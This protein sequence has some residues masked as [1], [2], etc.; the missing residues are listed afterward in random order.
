MEE[1]KEYLAGLYL[2]YRDEVHKTRYTCSMVK[3]RDIYIVEYIKVR[4]IIEIIKSKFERP[5]LSQHTRKNADL[6]FRKEQEGL[7]D[8]AAVESS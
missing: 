5:Q 8:K 1:I 2:P 4:R 6:G 3:K 7:R